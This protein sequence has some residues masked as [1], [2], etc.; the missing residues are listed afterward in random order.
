MKLKILQEGQNEIQDRM[1]EYP[2]LKKCYDMI[3]KELGC[4][5]EEIVCIDVHPDNEEEDEE[6][7]EIESFFPK[8]THP[9]AEVIYD[10]YC[11]N[12]FA[13]GCVMRIVCDGIVFVA[14]SNASPWCVYGNLNNI[15]Q[16]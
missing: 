12:D 3:A 2:G 1:R 9:E 14:E 5:I 16:E 4:K 10:D 15:N 11:T 7:W 13:V 6:G 8:E